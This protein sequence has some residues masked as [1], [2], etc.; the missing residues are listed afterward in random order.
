MKQRS[1]MQSNASPHVLIFSQWI[2]RL[3]SARGRVGISLTHLLV[4]G[5]HSVCH[6]ELR[7]D[8]R[9]TI[10]RNNVYRARAAACAQSDAC[11]HVPTYLPTGLPTYWPPYLP[12][13][14][15]IVKRYEVI[16]FRGLLI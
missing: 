1:T 12:H 8:I 13:V 4:C 2:V 6:T 5:P 7:T 3:M 10:Q 16:R 9:S 14:V 11:V 15:K